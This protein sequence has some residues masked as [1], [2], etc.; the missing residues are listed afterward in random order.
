MPYCKLTEK[1]FT[2]YRLNRGDVVIARMADPGHGVL[3]EE[4]LDSVFASY[5]IRFR[6]LH[7]HHSRLLQYW[8]RSS[9]YWELVLGRGAGTT[10]V[11]LNAKVLSEFSLVVPTASVTEFFDKHIASLRARVVGNASEIKTLAALRDTLIPKLI[12]GERRVRNVER[13]IGEAKS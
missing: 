7:E 12:S 1:D 4:N 6:P 10:R 3:I 5:L 11:S 2:K 13:R 8:L 9:R